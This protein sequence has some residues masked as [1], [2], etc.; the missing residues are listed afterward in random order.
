MD[1]DVSGLNLFTKRS[2]ATVNIIVS[3]LCDVLNRFNLLEVLILGPEHRLVSTGYSQD[4]AIGHRQFELI[5]NY[6][7]KILQPAG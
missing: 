6:G 3:I 2:L 5:G 7:R 1:R 4:E